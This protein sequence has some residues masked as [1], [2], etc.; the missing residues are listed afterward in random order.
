MSRPLGSTLP[1]ATIVT[2]GKKSP[3]FYFFSVF[4]NNVTVELKA[5]RIVKECCGERPSHPTP[6]LEL[7]QL[8]LARQ[9]N[10]KTKD[11]EN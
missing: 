5:V 4:F 11:K 3:S 7:E 9:E 10:T 8:N 6:V 2:E 1:R